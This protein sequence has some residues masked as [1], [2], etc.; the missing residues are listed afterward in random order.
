MYRHRRRISQSTDGSTHDAT[1]RF[2][3]TLKVTFTAFAIN[4][5]AQ[6]RIHQCGAF[7]ARSALTAGLVR[8]KARQHLQQAHHTGAFTD[9]NNATGA[10]HAAMLLQGLSIKGN[11]VD[12]IRFK[13]G[14]RRPARDHRLK[15]FVPFDTSSILVN[16]LFE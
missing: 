11:L 3:Q 13:N 16:N 7:P 2:L 15:L 14:G 4:N 12:F 5:A 6:D 8:I 1:G 9:D 10:D